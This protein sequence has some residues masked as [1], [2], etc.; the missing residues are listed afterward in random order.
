M[1]FSAKGGYST[2]RFPPMRIVLINRFYWPD[3]SSTAMLATDLAEDLAARG[4]EVHVLCARAT[5]DNA[6][7]KL[8]SRETRNGVIIHR[9]FSTRFGRMGALGRMGDLASFHLSLRLVG[10]WICKPDVIYC[11]TDPPMAL[12]AAVWISRLRGGKIVHHMMDVYPE[13]AVA[14]GVMREGTFAHKRLTR[15]Y[16]KGL[17]RCSK[18]IVLSERMA[19]CAVKKGA[20]PSNI[21]VV[22]PWSRPIESP[23]PRETNSFRAELGLTPDENLIIN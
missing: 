11:M 9:L 4:H 14:L 1:N 13:I 5:Y 6:R 10:P 8:P 23:P 3:E 19:E 12:G 21:V 15:I 7:T 22:P 20:D 2:S 18:V 17:A 16:R